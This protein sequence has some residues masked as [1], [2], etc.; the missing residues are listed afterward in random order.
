M[1]HNLLKQPISNAIHPYLLPTHSSWVSASAG[2]GKTKILTDRVLSLLLHGIGPEQILC[3]TFTKAAAAEMRSRVLNHMSSWQHMTHDELSKTLEDLLGDIPSADLVE[4]ATT[5]FP[6]MLEKLHSLKIQTIHSF[7][8][9]LLSQFPLEAGI[10]PHFTILD[11]LEGDRL[12][13]QCVKRELKVIRLEKPEWA[14]EIA[15]YHDQKSFEEKLRAMMGIEPPTP[16]ELYHFFNLPQG[17]T[18]EERMKVFYEGMPNDDR[19]QEGSREHFAEYRKIFLT[20][21]GT[22]RKRLMKKAE[23]E[24][25]P[26]KLARME[27]EA[28]RVLAF[29]NDLQ[30]LDYI[31]FSEILFQVTSRIQARY[32][33]VKN[34]RRVLDYDDLIRKTKDL[35][36]QPDVAPWILYKIDEAI[37]HILVDEAQDTNSAQW[38]IVEALYED[39][40]KGQQDQARSV[41]IVGDQKQ[42]IYGFQG[43]EPAYFK[44]AGEKLQRATFEGQS[45]FQQVSLDKSYRSAPAIL[46]AVD[47][48]FNQ[49]RLK[50]SIGFDEEELTHHI[51][52]TEAPGIVELW[53]L[54]SA[55]R[56]QKSEG[57][58]L[59]EEE[60]QQVDASDVLVETL[61]KKIKSCLE[62]GFLCDPLRPVEPKDILIL[63]RKRGKLMAKIVNALKLA[64]IPVAGAD[65]LVLQDEV[66]VLDLLNIAD[67][68]LFPEDDVALAN[69]LKSPFMGWSED[70]LFDLCQNK[71]ENLW[72]S[73][74]DRTYLEDLCEFSKGCSVYDFYS[75]ILFNEKGLEKLI[76][77]L[78]PECEEV[79]DAF[80]NLAITFENSETPSLQGFVLW[81]RSLS[82]ELKRDTE[83]GR[84]Q[85]RIMTIHGS[86]GLQAPL[87]FMAEITSTPQQRL[88]LVVE[89]EAGQILPARPTISHEKML[90]IKEQ[91]QKDERAEYDR[92]LYV[93]MTRAQDQLYMMGVQP[94]RKSA[95]GSWYDDIKIALEAEAQIFEPETPEYEGVKWEGLALRLADPVLVEMKSEAIEKPKKDDT[96]LPDWVVEV[97][98][99][100]LRVS[101]LPLDRSIAV[102]SRAKHKIEEGIFLHKLCEILPM[103]PPEKHV[104][105]AHTYLKNS[106]F[107]DNSE[108]ALLI[109]NLLT[110]VSSEETKWIFASGYSELPIKGEVD[111]ETYDVRLDRLVIDRNRVAIIDYKL[112]LPDDLGDY[113]AQLTLYKK[114]VSKL[115][116]GQEIQTYLLGLNE[117]KLLRVD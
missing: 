77:R 3:L 43:A 106:A 41:F 107:K 35:L 93:A 59:P 103:S 117:K 83:E 94:S 82:Q 49:A 79:V 48:V 70:Q 69:L 2:S 86:K 7:A 17:I 67:F 99:K 32:M 64:H 61:T 16:S 22:I 15:L 10:D 71:K 96:L 13:T 110:L 47:A 104:E 34:Q 18:R 20:S 4:R 98:N 115:Y 12:F 73:L 116:P 113:K 58:Q 88:P 6:L 29:E 45:G 91:H 90:E 44:N 85:V 51:H 101:H 28:E 19:P 23:A 92:L 27:D 9:N 11:P 52:R 24:K 102:G 56:P 84:N 5:L 89:T 62:E 26:E 97:T 81:M 50:R 74:D 38:Q 109:D 108:M 25:N 33:R 57:W 46:K 114:L 37:A 40:F 95:E 30:A 100:N 42:S 65:R 66:A 31:A 87:V 39:F 1:P 78:G 112:S 111:G 72:A 36:N 8:Q 54:I 63:L 105:I 21:D 60:T 55:P 75:H 76:T 80:L 53:P 14:R 68:V